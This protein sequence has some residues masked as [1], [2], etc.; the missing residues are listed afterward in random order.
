MDY[1]CDESRTLVEVR[2][3]L[4]ALGSA[5]EATL[6]SLGYAG[7]RKSLRELLGL[8]DGSLSI[9]MLLEQIG[10]RLDSHHHLLSETYLAKREGNHGDW[11]ARLDAT[12][13]CKTIVAHMGKD[14]YG[15]VHPLSARTLSAREAARIQSFP[16]WFSFA[17]QTLTETF[18]MIGNAV[19]PLLSSM[20]ASQIAATLALQDQHTAK[21]QLRR[22][23]R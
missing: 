21:L 16:D 5:D 10:M 20:L 17:G 23:L 18:R 9:R 22:A 2:L 15:Y 11:L 8:I 7:G 12:K 19:P 4:A 1:R 13:P 14:R 6:A 3:A